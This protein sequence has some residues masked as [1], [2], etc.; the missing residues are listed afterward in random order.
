MPMPRQQFIGP[1]NPHHESEKIRKMRNEA[2]ERERFY[3]SYVQYIQ[4][5]QGP[6]VG[7]GA[8]FGNG[9]AR[10]RF[11]QASAMYILTSGISKIISANSSLCMQF[12]SKASLDALQQGIVKGDFSKIDFFDAGLSGLN[13]STPL[14][15]FGK[16]VFD[17]SFDKGFYIKPNLDEIAVEFGVRQSL[18]Y[19]FKKPG[20]FYGDLGV[21][22]SKKKIKQFTMDS[23][24][25]I[26][27]DDS[28]NEE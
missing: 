5:T 7:G 24:K 28:N 14:K 16:S 22:L 27:S 13:I 3:S 6:V 18:G 11:V 2:V 17:W 1:Y 10:D 12:L 25:S 15:D 4:D 21:D 8:G 20:N 19:T 9:L 23:Y 26:N